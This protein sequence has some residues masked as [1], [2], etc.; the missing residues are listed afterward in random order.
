MISFVVPCVPVAQP[1]QRTRVAVINGHARAMNYTPTKHPA[2]QFK[3]AIQLAYSQAVSGPPFDGPISIN[4]AF[5][6]PR[7]KKFIWKKRDMPRVR[8]TG[9]P[10]IDNLT[11]CFLDALHGLAWRD[12]SQVCELSVS[13]DIAAGHE[14]P[15]VLV[16]LI[17]L[18]DKY[19]E[20][21]C[22]T[23]QNESLGFDPDDYPLF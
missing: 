14:S 9:K 4:V 5:L 1:R 17:P 21:V 20:L 13:K 6:M 10:D 22:G 18:D 3:A 19:R 15:Q 16:N 7:P 2:N 11:K 23:S 8:H 12:D